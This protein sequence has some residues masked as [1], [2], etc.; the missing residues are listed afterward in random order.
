MNNTQK[1][2]EYV[3]SLNKDLN[4]IEV[5]FESFLFAM[6]GGKKI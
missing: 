5:Q 3:A 1:N 2:E 4:E 6:Y